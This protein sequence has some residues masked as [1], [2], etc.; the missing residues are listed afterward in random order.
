MRTKD[1]WKHQILKRWYEYEKSPISSFSKLNTPEGH[2]PGR[3]QAFSSTSHSRPWAAL[4][5]FSLLPCNGFMSQSLLIVGEGLQ[6]QSGMDLLPLNRSQVISC[7]FYNYSQKVISETN[8]NSISHILQN[9][10]NFKEEQPF[11]NNF[12]K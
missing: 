4:R 12:W 6:R 8:S 1:I 7:A 10:Q 2:R 11:Q 3:P 9:H 5:K